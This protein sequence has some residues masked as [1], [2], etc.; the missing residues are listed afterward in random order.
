M[1]SVVKAA[2]HFHQQS[3]ASMEAQSPVTA[4]ISENP[5]RLLFT[6]PVVVLDGELLSVELDE[7]GNL[8]LSE[9]EMAPMYVGYKSNQY[10]RERYRVDLVRLNAL[11]RYLDIAERQHNAIRRAILELGGL[12]EYMQYMEEGAREQ[13]PTR[14]FR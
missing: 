10:E 1:I 3:Q 9:I 8:E 6:R 4:D 2:E 13:T 5:T 7:A 14:K 12:A 11:P